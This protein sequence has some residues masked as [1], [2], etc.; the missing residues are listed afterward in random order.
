MHIYLDTSVFSAY[1]DQRTPERMHLTMA[2]WKELEKHEKLCSDL[3]LEELGQVS[4]DMAQKLIALTSEFR[5]IPI[6]DQMKMLAQ[7]YVREGVVPKKYFSDAL[8]VAAAVLGGADI[9]ISWNFRH[10]VKR[11]T[12]L[13]I[14]YINTK[15]G[16]RNIEILAPPEI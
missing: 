1:Y 4:R 2:F 6:N 11:S 3:T 13:L 5:I 16:L 10:L 14:N 12:R 8:H 15:R 9:L 7:A